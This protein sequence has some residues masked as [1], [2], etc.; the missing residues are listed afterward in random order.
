MTA[1]QIATIRSTWNLMGATTD[2]VAP[3]FYDRLFQRDP[4]LRAL[5]TN[6]DMPSQ[7]EKLAQTLAVV[8]RGLDR[9]DQLLPAVQ[10]LGRRHAAY[11]VQDAHYD[12][13]GGALLDT[14]ADILGDAFTSEARAAWAEA[15]G[16]L[17]T[18]MQ[19]AA[20]TSVGVPQA[21][22]S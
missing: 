8:V 5:F 14:F 9:L 1:D 18:A 16:A 11:G 19:E 20:H 13:V 12:L 6:T 15:Y 3:L 22:D 4:L 17:A 2:A 21:R 10:A 7:G